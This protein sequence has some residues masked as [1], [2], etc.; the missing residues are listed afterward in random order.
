MGEFSS[1]LIGDWRKEL[2]QV[3]MV[4]SSGE[5]LKIVDF[6]VKPSVFKPHAAV[7]ADVFSKARG[8]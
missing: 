3:K 5:A 7:R 6:P 1:N 8:S 4:V 2:L